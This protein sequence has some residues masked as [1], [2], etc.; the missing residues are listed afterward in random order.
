M[1][2]RLVIR[3]TILAVAVSIVLSGC[4]FFID[5]EALANWT[6]DLKIE[7]E[8]DDDFGN[9]DMWVSYPRPANG[10][11]GKPDTTNDNYE[12]LFENLYQDI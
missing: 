10:P 12:P 11:S 3:I 2:K 1:N 8:W 6:A 7:A 5:A 9:V 4:I